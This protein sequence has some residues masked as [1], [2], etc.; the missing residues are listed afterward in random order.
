[1]SV[2]SAVLAQAAR[3]VAVHRRIAEWLPPTPLIASRADLSAGT[4]LHFKADNFQR[5]GSFK[6]RGAL[7]KLTATPVETPIVTASSGNHGIALATAAGLTGHK[8]RVV[9]PEAVARAKLERIAALG[10]ETILH[11]GDSGMAEQHARTLAEA[12]GSAYVSPYND[13]DIIAG[14]GTL[15]LEILAQLPDLD[16][17]YI[18]MGGGGLIS[19]TA[20]VLKAFGARVRIVGVS[21]TASAALAASLRAGKVVEVT[22]EDTLADGVAGGMDGDSITLPLAS[23]LVDDLIDCTE[24]Q[25]VQ[26]LRDIAWTEK[27]LVVG[28][29]ALPHAATAAD[30]QARGQS[31]VVVLCG[32]NFDQ[33]RIAPIIA[34]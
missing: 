27:M 17:V 18:A 24:A 4:A 10:V 34:G 21:A 8:V 7:S 32:A 30:E 22:H 3:S 9:L 14:Q 19:G 28:A 12:E 13:P 5:T 16:T 11:P 1:M 23:E 6:F 29:A 33:A 31:S 26:S 25:I 15:G 2:S 20:A